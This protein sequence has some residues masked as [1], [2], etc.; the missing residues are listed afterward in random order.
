MA[1]LGHTRPIVG[2][3][4]GLG[5]CAELSAEQADEAARSM[6]ALRAFLGRCAEIARPED[7]CPKVLMAIGRAATQPW[8]EADVRVE[9]SGDDAFTTIAV[10]YDHG[11]GIRERM[12]PPVELAAPIDEFH[13]AIRLAPALFAPLVL[14]VDDGSVLVLAAPSSGASTPH[15]AIR[16]DSASITAA[17]AAP[18]PRGPDDDAVPLDIDMRE[19]IAANGPTP[20]V[21]GA[22]PHTKPTQRM[23]TIDPEILRAATARRDPRRDDD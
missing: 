13:R 5:S 23:K 4:S 6:E 16:I 14:E 10:L 22:N 12:L 9:L 21:A 7:G 8:L 20:Y 17:S 18:Q 11:F 3:F 1:A 2:G 15:S 19:P